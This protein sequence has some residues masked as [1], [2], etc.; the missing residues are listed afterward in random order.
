MLLLETHFYPCVRHDFL[1]CKRRLR[2]DLMK[3]ETARLAAPGWDISEAIRFL[4]SAVKLGKK[5]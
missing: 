5:W 3:G 2:K 1:F 4:E